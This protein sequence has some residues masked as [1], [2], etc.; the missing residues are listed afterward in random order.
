MPTG[1]FRCDVM[2]VA[3]RSPSAPAGCSSPEGRVSA[4]ELVDPRPDVAAATSRR[5]VVTRLWLQ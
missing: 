2:R 3:A 5:G 1:R 4:I